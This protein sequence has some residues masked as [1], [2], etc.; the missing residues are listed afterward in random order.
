MTTR[1]ESMVTEVKLVGA[2]I[3]GFAGF[4]RRASTARSAKPW[5]ARFD[6]FDIATGVLLAALIVIALATFKD[7]AISNDEGVQ[8]HY[9]ELIIAYY[10]SGFKDQS[11]FSFQNLYLYGG[12]FDV[13][14]IALSQLVPIDP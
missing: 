7:Y 13:I 5:I 6:T 8:H 11:L 3:A 10:N 2:D 14:A 9:G 12:L 4:A 1:S